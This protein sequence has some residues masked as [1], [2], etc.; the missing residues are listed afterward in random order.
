MGVCYNQTKS[1]YARS[2]NVPWSIPIAEHALH[3]DLLYPSTGRVARG[4]EVRR[5]I[6]VVRL[7]RGSSEPVIR[8]QAWP[9][10]KPSGCNI[11]LCGV[12]TVCTGRTLDPE[13]S[14]TEQ[15]ERQEAEQQQQGQPDSHGEDI[16]RT[17]SVR[18][19]DDAV[20]LHT[21]SGNVV[22]T[23]WYLVRSSA[24]SPKF[25]PKLRPRNIIFGKTTSCTHCDNHNSRVSARHNLDKLSTADYSPSGC[26]PNAPKSTA[27]S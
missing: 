18:D 6:R 19:V 5:V 12:S 2:M 7:R 24:F 22:G 14:H 16:D 1:W 26:A 17:W 8:A 23:V 21:S 15:N 3:F 27:S 10:S 25:P 9:L 13:H 11:G 4:S 20:C